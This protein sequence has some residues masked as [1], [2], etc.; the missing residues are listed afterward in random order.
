MLVRLPGAVAEMLNE[1]VSRGFF[2]TKAEAVR[3]GILRLGQDYGLVKPATHY[4]KR[5]QAEVKES[6][7]RL[8]HEEIDKALKS[9]EQTA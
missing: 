1:L 4:W 8:T 6:G 7:K 2:S 3:A 9:L 5:L